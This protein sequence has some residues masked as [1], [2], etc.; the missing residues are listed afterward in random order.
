[1]KN[2]KMGFQVF[3]IMNNTLSGLWR[4]I[5]EPTSFKQSDR[6]TDKNIISLTLFIVFIIAILSHVLFSVGLHYDGSVI[7]KQMIFNNSFSF[8][9][10]SRRVFHFLYQIPA[11]LFIRFAPSDS[12][13]LL[14][15]VFSFGLIWIHIFSIM[16]CWLILPREKKSYIFFPLFAF[17]VG[18]SNR[19]GSLYLCL[20]FRFSVMSGLR[21]SLFTTLI[22]P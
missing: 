5:R 10:T 1:M 20:S 6:Y 22:C 8:Y 2:F 12:L 16:G 7:L 13:Y 4:K 14:A 11:W 17:L 15:Q 21:L 9:E 19:L 18:P 3:E